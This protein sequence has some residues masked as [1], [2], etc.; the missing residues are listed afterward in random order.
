MTWTIM[1]I[2][3]VHGAGFLERG[4][5]TKRDRMRPYQQAGDPST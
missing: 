2:V 4:W 3:V 5:L 1:D